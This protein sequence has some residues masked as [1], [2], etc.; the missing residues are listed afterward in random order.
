MKRY[1]K[2]EDYHGVLKAFFYSNDPVEGIKEHLCR[3]FDYCHPT[4]DFE[5][6]VY[7]GKLLE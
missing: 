6:W 5:V 1:I 7:E 2:V 4:I 3:D